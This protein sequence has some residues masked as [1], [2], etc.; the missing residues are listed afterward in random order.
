MPQPPLICLWT[1]DQ[2]PRK[3]PAPA[4]GRYR[5]RC[6]HSNDGDITSDMFFMSG[7]VTQTLVSQRRL[8]ARL[9]RILVIKK[10]QKIL[11]SSESL[12]FYV[13]LVNPCSA[14]ARV[15]LNGSEFRYSNEFLAPPP[16]PLPSDIHNVNTRH[17]NDVFASKTPLNKVP[18]GD[19]EIMQSLVKYSW[20]RRRRGPAR[21]GGGGRRCAL[22]PARARSTFGRFNF[23]LRKGGGRNLN[24]DSGPVLDSFAIPLSVPMP[25]IIPD[26]NSDFAPDLKCGPTLIRFQ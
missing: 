14:P 18:Q 20:R 11:D 21:G 24:S 5:P 12:C 8:R 23:P 22:R 4:R 3:A 15:G 7:L 25:L 9:D 26:P 10:K 2:P 6:Y 13:S 17:K 16:R 19:T 1:H